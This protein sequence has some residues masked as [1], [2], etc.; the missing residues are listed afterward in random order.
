MRVTQATR[1]KTR[2]GILVAARIQFAE[3]GY[4]EAKTRAIATAAGI[5]TGTLFNYFS[6]KEALGIALVSEAIVAAE[7]EFDSSR[8]EGE[9]LEETLFAFIATKLRHL[10]PL[11]SWAPTVLDAA[12]SPLRAE[13]TDGVGGE[14]RRHHLERVDEWI[15]REP[16]L[17]GESSERTVDLHLYWSLYLGV[18]SFWAHDESHNQEA[19]LALLDRSVG[20]FCN[21]LQEK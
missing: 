14:M 6:S 12:L 10:D 3:V 1:E 4:E 5:A 13:S 17:H 18:V 15:R 9:S 7:S 11:R 8:R 16:A 20:L 21:A 2:Q 19:T